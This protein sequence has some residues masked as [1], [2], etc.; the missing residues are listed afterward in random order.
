MQVLSNAPKCSRAA[1][2][3]LHDKCEQI[4]AMECVHVPTTIWLL[5]QFV[6]INT[7]RYI[8]RPHLQPLP[9]KTMQT[10]LLWQKE[11]LNEGIHV[12]NA[13]MVHR[14]GKLTNNI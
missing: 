2:T 1:L 13:F 3:I 7:L 6:L 10:H 5:Y 12:Y 9:I 14:P 4:T 8:H 11:A